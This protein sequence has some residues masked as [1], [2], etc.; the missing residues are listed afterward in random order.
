MIM[1]QSSPACKPMIEHRANGR[2]YVV[3]RPKSIN[4]QAGCCDVIA[5]YGRHP[6]HGYMA[7]VLFQFQLLYSHSRCIISRSISVLGNGA[8]PKYIES[9]QI[10]NQIASFIRSDH[11]EK[12]T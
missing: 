5:L 9:N 7:T 11:H 3:S 12:I 1:N 2:S 10:L 6:S 4:N 8:K